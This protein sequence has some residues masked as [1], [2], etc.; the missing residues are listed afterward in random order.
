MIKEL[1]RDEATRRTEPDK[2]KHFTLQVESDET[3]VVLLEAIYAYTGTP[4]PVNNTNPNSPQLHEDMRDT[5]TDD[6]V[7]KK[8]HALE[9]IRLRYRRAD[10]KDSSEGFTLGIP[11]KPVKI[12]IELKV[13]QRAG[14]SGIVDLDTRWYG[15][16][17]GLNTNG[18]CGADEFTV[19]PVSIFHQ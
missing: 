11:I 8:T 1:E 4:I 5:M 10:A 14:S 19:P 12:G 6:A 16:R 3:S 17:D 18:G 7:I 13:V 9:S 15:L 2:T